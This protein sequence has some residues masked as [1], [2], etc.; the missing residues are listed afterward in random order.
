MENI[1]RADKIVREP[2]SSGM[3]LTKMKPVSG[4]PGAANNVYLLVLL[5]LGVTPQ[6]YINQFILVL[7]KPN[8]GFTFLGS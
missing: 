7:G 1:K 3:R 2:R 6:E 8:T 5:M 4:C